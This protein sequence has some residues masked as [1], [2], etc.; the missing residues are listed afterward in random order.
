MLLEDYIPNINKKFKKF[1]FSGISFDSTKVK[2][3]DIFFAIRGSKIDGNNF[4][5][6]A[7]KRGSKIIITEK[8]VK[9]FVNGVLFIQTRNIRKLLAKVSFKIYKNK[10]KN[11]IAVTGTNGKSSVANF[12]YQIL[13]LNKKKSCFHRNVRSE[14]K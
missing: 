10:P 12:Y 1:F 6:N 11:L 14:I 3:D 13:N 7:I 2:K 8:K 4:I 5:P 9:E